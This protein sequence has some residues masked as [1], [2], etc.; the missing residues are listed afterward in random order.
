MLSRRHCAEFDHAIVRTEKTAD[1]ISFCRFILPKDESGTVIPVCQMSRDFK[2]AS[3]DPV[4]GTREVEGK[5]KI[6]RMKRP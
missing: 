1:Q 4:N 5:P 6:G 3:V 2:F